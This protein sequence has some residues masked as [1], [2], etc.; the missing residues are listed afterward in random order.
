LDG[1][2]EKGPEDP[3]SFPQNWNLFCHQCWL[4]AW[5]HLFKMQVFF[6]FNY[7]YALTTSSH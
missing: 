4:E 7:I 3:L 5:D 2:N 6:A 1:T